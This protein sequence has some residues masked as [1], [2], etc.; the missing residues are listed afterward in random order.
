[1]SLNSLLCALQHWGPPQGTSSFAMTSSKALLNPSPAFQGP[2][3][4]SSKPQKTPIPTIWGSKVMDCVD[5]PLGFQELH[6]PLLTLSNLFCHLLLFRDQGHA[7]VEVPVPV[8]TPKSGSSPVPIEG[9]G[10]TPI[11]RTLPVLQWVLQVRAILLARMHQGTT[12]S[13]LSIYALVGPSH[14]RGGAFVAK[15]LISEDN[16]FY[17][18][19]QYVSSRSISARIFT[20]FIQLQNLLS[21]IS[22]A[23]DT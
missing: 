1:M 17:P 2:L 7:H 20:I 6:S 5:G 8:P 15:C 9:R 10:S 12:D 14:V 16:F 22:H 23:H 11:T 18:A 3:S 4:P 13:R 21:F 19:T